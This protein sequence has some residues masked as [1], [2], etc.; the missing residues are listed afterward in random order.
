ME[1]TLTAKEYRVFYSNHGYF[2]ARAFATF[3]LAIA[4]AKNIHF[5]ATIYE[6][7]AGQHPYSSNDVKQV[8]S[9]SVFGG[10]RDNRKIAKPY[11]PLVTAALADGRKWNGLAYV[12]DAPVDGCECG[13]CKGYFDTRRSA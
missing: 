8:G 7:P 9:W 10:T 1:N 6:L 12:H 5:D 4:H 2:A 3:D 11:P 13:S